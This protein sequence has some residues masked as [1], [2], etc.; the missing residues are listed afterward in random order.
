MIMATMSTARSSHRNLKDARL[1]TRRVLKS[2]LRRTLI[3]NLVE[4][5]PRWKAVLEIEEHIHAQAVREWQTIQ[6]LFA[7]FDELSHVVTTALGEVAED[8]KDSLRIALEE[9][10]SGVWVDAEVDRYVRKFN[11]LAFLQKVAV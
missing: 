1:I 4:E 10:K 7:N 11:L 6:P 3:Q 8:S 9:V 2:D 5:S